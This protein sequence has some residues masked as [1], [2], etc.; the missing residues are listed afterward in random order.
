[1]PAPLLSLLSPLL[2]SLLAET[3]DLRPCLSLPCST[4]TIKILLDYLARGQ[5]QG[6]GEEV[7]QLA[8]IIGVTYLTEK[9]QVYTNNEKKPDKIELP[10]HKTGDGGGVPDK[11]IPSTIDL[12]KLTPETEMYLKE[13][14]QKNKNANDKRSKPLVP[15]SIRQPDLLNT[16]IEGHVSPIF[17][18]ESAK[19][20]MKKQGSNR[21]STNTSI[22]KLETQTDKIKVTNTLCNMFVETNTPTKSQYQVK[23]THIDE[24]FSKVKL[25]KQT[26]DDCG[27]VLSHKY[28][29]KNH[30]VS[31]HGSERNKYQC[32]QC[33]YQTLQK[34]GLEKHIITHHDNIR[35][36]CNLC[37]Y[38]ATQKGS[39][40]I[41]RESKH[42]GA[43]F[44][45]EVCGKVFSLKQ[46]QRAHM[47]YM[48]GQ[49]RH[50]CDSC[51]YIAGQAT[52]L[53]T[54]KKLK[55]SNMF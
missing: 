32:D 46:T 17:V 55:H 34:A 8:S 47:E 52:H 40:K 39:L 19:D 42:E 48:H 3:G 18:D 9:I 20:D 30:Q 26:C 37:D 14:I 36:P 50:K 27:T 24:R 53:T 28:A 29:L 25:E 33:K 54:H 38:K 10:T 7:V 21:L 5:G 35:Y 1:M 15:M 11:K 45:C 16:E 44:T 12:S 31:K 6:V 2:A 51:D 13:L 49:K 23:V 43:Q 22:L 41:H 4:S